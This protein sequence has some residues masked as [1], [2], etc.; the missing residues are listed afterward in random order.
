V[1]R[2]GACRRVGVLGGARLPNGDC[3]RKGA[4]AC[5]WMR[6]APIRPPSRSGPRARFVPKGI[7]DRLETVRCP[8]WVMA[9]QGPAARRALRGW[10]TSDS[11]RSAPLRGG[12]GHSGA[13]PHQISAHTPVLPLSLNSLNSSTIRLRWQIN[14][15]QIAS[16]VQIP[17]FSPSSG[18]TKAP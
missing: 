12:L 15:R 8:I 5:R 11:K 13:S 9:H 17:D 2:G 16:R 7:S 4:D 14:G 1:R 3:F 18:P 6:A 10:W